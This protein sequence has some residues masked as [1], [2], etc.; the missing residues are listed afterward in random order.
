MSVSTPIHASNQTCS[1][2]INSINRMLTISGITITTQ[3][4]AYSPHSIAVK[5]EQFARL[6]IFHITLFRASQSSC[7]F[8]P[9]ASR[10]SPFGVASTP[11]AQVITPAPHG[12]LIAPQGL[13]RKR[14]YSVWRLIRRGH[15]TS[16]MKLQILMAAVISIVHPQQW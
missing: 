13:V 15:T 6:R 10:L 3:P 7:L 9:M 2:S 4:M 11:Q 8:H 5:M 12:Q 14:G 16:V 1:V